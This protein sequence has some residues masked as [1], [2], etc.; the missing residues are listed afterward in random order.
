[1]KPTDTCWEKYNIEESDFFEKLHS[2]EYREKA[3]YEFSLVKQLQVKG[4]PAVLIGVSDSKF[5][6]VA[7]GYTDYET[8]KQRIDK[9]LS[10]IPENYNN[11]YRLPPC[12]NDR[13]HDG[14]GQHLVTAIYKNIPR[15]TKFEQGCNGN[16]TKHPEAG[17]KARCHSPYKIGFSVI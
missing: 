16:P 8:L 9:V 13:T 2:E 11:S 15:R 10:E 17:E 5:Y 6:L 7:S 12:A 14:K 3:Y 4:F 1:M